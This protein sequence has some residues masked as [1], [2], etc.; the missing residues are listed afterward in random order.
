MLT[1]SVVIA[2]EEVEVPFTGIG[3]AHCRHRSAKSI[4][5]FGFGFAGFKVALND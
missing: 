3:R 1:R 5:A 2:L 4:L